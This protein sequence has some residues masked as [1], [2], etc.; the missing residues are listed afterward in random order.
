M[1]HTNPTR[2]RGR[3]ISHFVTNENSNEPT[4]M[5]ERI[6]PF[7]QTMLGRVRDDVFCPRSRVGLVL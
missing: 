4:P 1:L 2:E 3:R 6:D 5:R 7:S